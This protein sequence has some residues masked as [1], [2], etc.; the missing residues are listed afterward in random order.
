M[1]KIVNG[2]HSFCIIFVI[3]ILHNPVSY[4]H[5]VIWATGTRQNSDTL[6]PLHVNSDAITSALHYCLFHL[7]LQTQ[8]QTV[9]PQKGVMWT[10]ASFKP[11][12]PM[13]VSPLTK[14]CVSIQSY[15]LNCPVLYQY[16]VADIRFLSNTL[17]LVF[18][19][20]R[21]C[22]FTFKCLLITGLTFSEAQKNIRPW[23]LKTTFLNLS[24]VLYSAHTS[25]IWMF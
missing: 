23:I 3:L 4:H 14:T 17:T 10:S 6:D 18:M 1:W 25:L 16:S 5:E 7:E 8:P 21:P 24:I 13:P 2:L 22:H 19:W 15:W 12:Y 9:T 20:K 11:C